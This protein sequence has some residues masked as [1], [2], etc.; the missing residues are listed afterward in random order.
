MTD[1]EI[2]DWICSHPTKIGLRAEWSRTIISKDNTEVSTLHYTNVRKKVEM[3]ATQQD[4]AGRT[5]Q[6]S[7][8]S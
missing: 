1:T 2:L 4:L 5:S 6:Q 3:L 7:Q 8:Y